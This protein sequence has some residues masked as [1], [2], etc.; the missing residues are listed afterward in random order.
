MHFHEYSQVR[1]RRLLRS[2][3]SSDDF[4][5]YVRPPQVGDVGIVV[6]VY[7]RPGTAEGYC[8]TVECADGG[9]TPL[10]LGDLSAEELEAAPTQP[11]P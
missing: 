10:W 9:D 4:I 1:I 7:Q 11:S 6:S 8:Y 5:V 2:P 3:D